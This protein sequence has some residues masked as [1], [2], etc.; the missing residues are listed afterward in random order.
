MTPSVGSNITF[1]I[2]VANAG[3]SSATGV[4][5]TDLLSSGYSFVSATP[6]QGNYVNTTGLWTVGSLSNGGSASLSVTA[7][8]NASGSY[9]NT[10]EITGANETDVDST[11]GNHDGNEDDQK[12]VTPIPR[13]AISGKVYV[14][15]NN[16]GIADP[17]ETGL[18]VVSLTLGGY[19]FGPDG[20]DNGG[21]GDDIVVTDSKMTGAAGDYSFNELAPGTYRVIQLAQ[22][23][24][25]LNG[26]TTVGSVGGATTPVAT[27]PS[28]I[29]GIALSGVN[30]SGNNFG[31]VVAASLAGQVYED[32]DGNGALDV[33]E[34]GL[35][36]VGV[37][38]TG[39]SDMG[40]AVNQ[41]TVT[42]AG[43]G[44]TFTGLRPGNYI[45]TESQPVDYAE[46]A[47]LAGSAGG[48]AGLSGTNSEISGISLA[49]G[50]NA[51][52]YLFGEKTGVIS[53]HVYLDADNDGIWDVG[54]TGISGVTLTLSGSTASG[55]AVNA[56]T[57]TDSNGNYRFD[58]VK[59]A[60]DS[61][62]SL[63]ETQPG[64]YLDG[65]ETAGSQAGTVDNASFSNNV[66]QNQISGIAFT[67]AN[68]ATDYNFAEL[69][70]ASL[71][72]KVWHDFAYGAKPL[73][74][75]QDG[76]EPGLAGVTITLTGTDDLGAAVSQTTTTGVDGHYR[77]EGLRPGTYQVAETQP[78]GVNDFAGVTGTLVG[79]IGGN[80]GGVANQNAISSIV[81]AS[82]AQAVEYNFR[83]D[84]SVLVGGYVYLD[85]NGSHT[86]DAGDT[87]IAGVTLSL[88]T[89]NGRCADGGQT[90]TETSAADGG[91][92]FAGLR[93]GT[94]SI[95]ET[96]PPIYKD[97]DE[98]V[99]LVAG[100]ANGSADNTAYDATAQ[101]N[102]ITG[103]TLGLGSQATGYH[104]GELDGVFATIAGTAWINTA[105]SGSRTSFDPGDTALSGWRVELVHN[106][107]VS[108]STITGADGAYRIS[109]VTPDYNYSV[110]FVN[111]TN[112][113]VWGSPVKNGTTTNPEGGT[114][115]V[116]P[117]TGAIEN[118]TVPSAGA[119]T[120]LDLPI[121]PSGVVY[122]SSTGVPV[123]GVTVTMSCPGLAATDMVG[124][125]LTQVTD[126]SGVYAFFVKPTAPAGNFTC[127]F[128]VDGPSGV[129][130]PG[131]SS[132]IPACTSSLTI[133]STTA[134]GPEPALVQDNAS[135]PGAADRQAWNAGAAATCAANTG[136]G[137]FLIGATSARYYDTMVISTAAPASANLINNNIP[138]DP[139]LGG[140]IRMTKTTPL[141]NVSRGDLVPY[142]ITAHNTQSLA[143][144]GINLQDLMPPGFKYK[145]GSA[146]FDDDCDGASAATAVE[147]TINNRML[148][149]PNRSFA[150][151]SATPDST[152]ECKRIRLMLVV[153]SGVG[154]G[155]YTNL[156]WAL[157][158][159][160]LASNVATAVV[161]VVPEPTF[162]CSDI[163]GKVF[164]DQNA[165]GYQDEGEPGIP[166]VRLATARG[167]LV[168]T[169]SEGRFHVACAV[170]PQAQRGSNFIMK[171]DERT[172]PSGYRI[173]TENPREVRATRGKLV[174]LNFGAA[175]HRL[176]RVELTG[177][178]F[179]AE[180]DEPAAALEKAI[181]KLPQTLRAKPSVIRLAYRKGGE[182]QG[183]I[184]ARLRGVRERLEKLW[185]EQGCCYTLVFEEEI[186][187][188]SAGKKR[189]AK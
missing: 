36:G 139:I 136:D 115:E 32:R 23:V 176:V 90:C 160:T 61:G 106:G 111:P 169:D 45:V 94:Y 118:I 104:F 131:M 152:S 183:L 167:L 130:K 3:P 128:A 84:A 64:A 113:Q 50:I 81:I 77:F 188:R 147:P 98:N 6:S 34:P 31:E 19:A 67:A 33:G 75:V 157:N 11:P 59:N 145:P 25:T 177:S 49:S 186:F 55:V 80:V 109:T 143:L 4:V 127:S 140:A 63:S 142:T 43:G 58:Q 102:R 165:N 62:Y 27:T 28:V 99:G 48:T 125:S 18:S 78:T 180:K 8:V 83:E 76:D 185:K 2:S 158:G 151:L 161:R 159:A 82:G 134:G 101:H 171:L 57:M 154:E 39:F 52:G 26:R 144:T 38:L 68:S 44:W 96:Q 123:S 150:T 47:N 173:T 74:S 20:I 121:D 138:I 29:S 119:I 163:I 35:V 162:D 40:I 1:T 73:N 149:W 46:G 17:G 92:L 110:R 146:R 103:I 168:T 66:A 42:T 100:V 108:A 174:K 86:R 135:A 114:I 155:E 170:I 22:P 95:T 60:S 71:T 124:N 65:R 37:S 51:S 88:A 179:L 116:N 133:L 21:A 126:A 54:E 10:A 148:T 53:G 132:T 105:T 178:A 182:A 87:G 137:T 7:T 70:A 79:N 85:R 13:A 156:T 184:E 93:S 9:A 14:D 181:A 107:N 30:S 189:S 117:V 153:G 166:N 187:E 72:G 89:A 41:T 172:L 12:T 122:D 97:A 15:A 91:Y 16:D 164:D 56:S 24:G 112:G 141:I 129:Y 69:L 5:V 175:I 120:G